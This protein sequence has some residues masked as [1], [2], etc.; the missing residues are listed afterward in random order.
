MSEVYRLAVAV[1]NQV[2]Q[3]LDNFTSPAKPIGG[4]VMAHA[5][6]FRIR[7]RHSVYRRRAEL[8]HSPYLQEKYAYFGLS[9][10]GVCDVTIPDPV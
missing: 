5:S 4:N 10:E 7:L 6:T 1:T 8:T 3:E 2:N 9:A